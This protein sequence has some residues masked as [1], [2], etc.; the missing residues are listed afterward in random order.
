MRVPSSSSALR[1]FRLLVRAPSFIFAEVGSQC[2]CKGLSRLF[3]TRRA[4]ASVG[5]SSSPTFST[6]CRDHRLRGRSRRGVAFTNLTAPHRRLST[7]QL[8]DEDTTWARA[9]AEYYGPGNYQLFRPLYKDLCDEIRNEFGTKPPP[10]LLPVVSLPKPSSVSA[11]GGNHGTSANNRS[12]EK[13]GEGLLRKETPEEGCVGIKRGQETSG[14]SL[15]GAGEEGGSNPP[16]V[17]E[18][19]VYGDGSWSVA[20]DPGNNV[21]TFRRDA[22]E[23]TRQGRIVV[24]A[25]VEIKDPPKL[26]AILTFVDWY[27]FEVLL[28]RK[29]VI[30][31]FSVACNEGGMHLRNVRAYDAAAS[32]LLMESTDDA[33]WVRRNLFYDGPCLWHLELDFHNELYD[34]MQDH[35]VDLDWVRWASRWVFYLEHVNYTRWNLGMLEELIPS[36]LRGPEEDFLLDKERAALEEPVEES[37]SGRGL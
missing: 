23:E 14:A 5:H 18:A 13:G 17:E 32:P 35:G 4:A 8:E 29:G 9:M 20:Y 16:R 24:Y 22:I 11:Q 31:H 37:L 12:T 25:P 6:F 21:V 10:P 27:P 30:L 19:P 26:N 36:D 28:M 33:E 7:V 3:E 34:I 15:E 1:R 2:G